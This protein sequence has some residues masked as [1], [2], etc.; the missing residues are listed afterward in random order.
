MD[1][2]RP[3]RDTHAHEG[4]RGS[5]DERG[6][7]LM[8]AIIATVVAVLAV[9]GLAHTFGLGHGFIDGFSASRAA[10]GEAQRRMEWLAAWPDSA[11]L[12][13]DGYHPGAP[14]PVSIPG[15]LDASVRWRVDAY[16]DPITGAVTD[17]MRLVTVLVAY[18]TMDTQDTAKVT[19][20]F[21]NP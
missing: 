8:E 13:T 12:F 10:L 14:I 9:I 20:L 17:D 7:S 2:V 19:R 18:R 15:V 11:D 3:R 21:Q 5:P 16:D 6:F 4:R 1:A